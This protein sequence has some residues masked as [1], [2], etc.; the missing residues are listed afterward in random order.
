MK[1]I[2]NICILFL[3]LA[4]QAKVSDVYAETSLS[5][6]LA[7]CAAIDNNQKR[8]ACYDKLARSHS[9]DEGQSR[10]HQFIQPPAAFLDSHL[11]A[12]PWKA[13]YTLTVR[14]FAELISQAVMKD[15]KPVTVQGWSRDK[16]DYVLNITMKT[17]LQLHFLPRKSASQDM[18]MS[19]LRDVKMNGYTL[20]ADQFILTIAAMVPDKKDGTD[21]TQ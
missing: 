19:L 16:G 1:Y 3:F 20:G 4:T 9:S 7:R 15:K 21:N 12:E 11:V 18:A 2:P 5:Q 6:Q 10:S 13:E 8:L 17:P 14:S